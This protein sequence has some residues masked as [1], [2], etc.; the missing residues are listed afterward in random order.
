V[1]GGEA[2]EMGA[3]LMH[4]RAAEMQMDPIYGML[5]S[6]LYNP[7]VQHSVLAALQSDPNYARMAKNPRMTQPQLMCPQISCSLQSCNLSWPAGCAA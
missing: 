2:E 5:N 4:M 7:E 1:H 6:V 3:P